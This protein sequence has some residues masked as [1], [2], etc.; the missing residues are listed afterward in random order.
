M[1]FKELLNPRNTFTKVCFIAYDFKDVDNAIQFCLKYDFQYYY[2]KHK[3]ESENEEIEK[4][5]HYHFV[6][7]SDY[8]HRFHL[9]SLV[10]DSL[11]IN[12]FDRCG[13]VKKYLRYLTHMDYVDKLHYDVSDIISNVPSDVIQVYID[14]VSFIHYSYNDLS[15]IIIDFI[16]ST[17]DVPKFT[18][19]Y[20]YLMSQ[21]IPLTPQ[22]NGLIIILIKQR[23][24][25]L[26]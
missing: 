21:H 1:G 11:P 15:K 14:S 3:G 13:D 7:E 8:N 5:E 22:V 12:L 6:I 16:F 17:R 9:T 4:K 18:D 19:V 23:L 24:G 25:K 10:S 20:N 2:I 26:V